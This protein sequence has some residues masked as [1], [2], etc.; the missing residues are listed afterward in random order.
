MKNVIDF[1][2]ENILTLLDLSGLFRADRDGCANESHD[3]GTHS[4]STSELL[5]SSDDSSGKALSFE[6]ICRE[7]KHSRKIQL[8]L[9]PS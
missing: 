8:I 4:S 3:E 9:T 2:L 6:A 5:L 7:V 1:V